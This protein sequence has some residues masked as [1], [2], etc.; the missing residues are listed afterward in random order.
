MALSRQPLLQQRR[1]LR[2]NVQA[3]LRIAAPERAAA[4][5]AKKTA[6]RRAGRRWTAR[7]GETRAGFRRAL[8]M[9]SSPYQERCTSS[10][11]R[12]PCTVG[13][14]RPRVRSNSFSPSTFSQRASSRLTVG[15]EVCSS[16]RGFGQIAGGHHRVKNFDMAQ[17]NWLRAYAGRLPW[18]SP[19]HFCIDSR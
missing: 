4:A 8:T 1:L 13:C 14:S 10:N 7:P 6:K 9:R 19:Y 17:V 15:C 16:C 18:V 11:S 3:D 5:S 12:S 2:H